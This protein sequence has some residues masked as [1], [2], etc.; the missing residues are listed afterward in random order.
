MKGREQIGKE[1]SIFLNYWLLE[2]KIRLEL[3]LSSSR[4]SG[5]VRVLNTAL[6]IRQHQRHNRRETVSGEHIG[7][8]MHIIQRQTHSA[9]SLPLA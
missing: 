7:R 8:S 2:L 3:F 9:Y 1:I 5:V 4:V 6:N